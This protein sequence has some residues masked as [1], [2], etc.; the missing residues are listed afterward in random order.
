MVGTTP[1]RLNWICAI[2][3]KGTR[4]AARLVSQPAGPH[5][6]CTD[7]L[8]PHTLASLFPLPSAEE[9]GTLGGEPTDK[10]LQ[11]LISRSEIPNVTV[12]TDSRGRQ[13]PSRKPRR[14]PAE[15]ENP[16]REEP[17]RIDGHDEIRVRNRRA[18]LR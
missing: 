8:E 2:S 17:R 15:P 16:L 7:H 12:R 11:Y 6:G 13:Q 10:R 4:N 9:Y 3:S 1:A 5:D 18:E 14:K